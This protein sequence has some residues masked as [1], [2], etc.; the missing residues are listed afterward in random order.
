MKRSPAM[1]SLSVFSIQ[2]KRSRGW[3]CGRASVGG[4]PSPE[5]SLTRMRFLVSALLTLGLL[6]NL[7]VHVQAQSAMTTRTARSNRS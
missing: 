6:L 1:Y 7:P 5:R 4:T 3:P 2:L